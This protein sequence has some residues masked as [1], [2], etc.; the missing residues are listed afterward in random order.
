MKL[1]H[2]SSRSNKFAYLKKADFPAK[3]QVGATKKDLKEYL[4]KNQHKP[5]YVKY[6]DF[7]LLIYLAELM[8]I[9]TAISIA[10][11]VQI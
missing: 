5:S 9:Q 8:D 11:S 2:G 1:A 7:N 10:N 3:N 6:G 4:K